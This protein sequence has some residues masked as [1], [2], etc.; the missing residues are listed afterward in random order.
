MQQGF[1]NGI[2]LCSYEAAAQGLNTPAAYV[3]CTTTTSKKLPL[4]LGVP[5]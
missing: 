2:T 4:N 1:G 5:Y 3:T